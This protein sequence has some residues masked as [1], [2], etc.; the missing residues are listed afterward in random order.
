MTRPCDNVQLFVDGELPPGEAE[1]FRQHLPDCVRCQ[2]EVV[3]LLQLKYLGKEALAR[4]PDPVEARPARGSPPVWRL[5]GARVAAAFVLGILVTVGAVRWLSRAPSEETQSLFA[6]GERRR[7]APRLTHR[8]AD[9]Y[10]PLVDPVMSGG[11]KMPADE[12]PDA[13]FAALKARNDIPGLVAARLEQNDPSQARQALKAL[14][15][16]EPSAER[17]SNRAA[18]LLVLGEA[19]EALK[20]ADAALARSPRLP[21]ALWNRALALQKLHLPLRAAR[22]FSEVAALEDQ[23]PGWSK[24]ARDNAA[25]LRTFTQGSYLRWSEVNQAA[26]ALMDAPPKA[27][28][29]NFAQAPSAR[30][31]FYDAVRAA[32]DREQ[33]RALLDLARELDARVG[34]QVLQDY[35]HRVAAADF[36]RRAPLARDYAA[37][38]QALWAQDWQA[39]LPPEQRVPL[40]EDQNRLL[41]EAWQEQF[42]TR[43]RAAGED[44]LLLGTLVLVNSIRKEPALLE[45]AGKTDPWFE[46]A[47]ARVRAAEEWS[48]QQWGRA[49]RTLLEA[50]HRWCSVPGLAYRCIQLDI[51]LSNFYLQLH[52]LADASRHAERGMQR[53]REGSEWFLERDLLWTLAQ[54][55]KFAGDAPQLASASYAEL[56]EREPD[57][58]ETRRSVHQHLADIAWNEL[59]VDDARRGID[60]AMATGLP[61]TGSGAFT[62]AD[63]AR[64]KHAPG[65]EARLIEARDS[66][67]ESK[68]GERWVTAHALGRF[69]IERDVARGRELLW[70]LIHQVSAPAHA[71]NPSARRVRAYSFTSLVFEAG[72]RGAF[73]EA[74]GLASQE[75]GLPLPARCL[76]VATVDSE[77]TLLLVRGSQG[78][79]VGDYDDSRRERLKPELDGLVSKE[80]LL[81]PLRACE[82]VAV[83]A[84]PPLHGRAG[85]LPPEFAWSYLTRRSEAPVSPLPG[86]GRHVVVFNVELPPEHKQL[87][88]LTWKHGVGPD[89]EPIL[90]SGARATPSNVLAEMREATEVDLVTHGNIHSSASTSYLLLAPGT[91]GSELSLSRVRSASLRGAPFVVLAACKAAHTTYAVHEPLSLP[92]A[93]FDA[94]AR[95]VLAA[96]KDIF[97]Q[98]ANAFFNDVRKRM[99]EGKPP[100]IALRD[101]RQEALRAGVGT[102]WLGSVL[103][104]E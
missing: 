71:G 97:N 93:F 85:I 48:A 53:A 77:R 44:D 61:L 6:Q 24:E 91:E 88:R 72:R 95:G 79:L 37:L 45:A 69:V 59:R 78:E 90:L 84:R 100:A 70:E 98:E 64:F 63:I 82:Q 104:F 16:L 65:D 20:A 66:V 28:P 50:H 30:L 55:T 5:P 19:H 36:N 42:L 80:T 4:L 22:A 21:Q 101:A 83:L 32:P 3:A 8:L 27:L 87:P 39:R 51:D 26:K 11:A 38:V 17:E 86:P 10:R 54:T 40:T 68:Q 18:A 47:A 12:S 34:G 57:N 7:L 67:P 52:Q 74:M 25:E 46:L 1:S 23:E 94:G 14:E 49:T 29:Q 58:P 13:L 75:R 43:L 31:Y 92:A 15:G 76:L 9:R 41:K 73:E 35:V 2:R 81:A 103:L 99:R 56:L 33:V 62:L 102:Q 89:E 60:A 96:T